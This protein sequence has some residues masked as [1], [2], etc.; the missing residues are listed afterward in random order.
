TR[1]LFRSWQVIRNVDGHDADEIKTALETARKS[2]DRPTLICCKTTIGFGSPN[3]Q[4]K[5]ECHGAPLGNDEIALTRANLGWNHG[6]FEV[7]AEIYA[8]WDA[9]EAGA[10]LEAEWN[11]RFAAYAAE[12]PELAAEYQRRI[13]GE[14]PA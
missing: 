14:L 9:K 13:K 5:E 11:A 10:A 6:P 1:R 4:G 12:Y 7:P 8:E 2:A 3:K